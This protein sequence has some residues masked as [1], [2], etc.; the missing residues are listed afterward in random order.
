MK[1]KDL[2]KEDT[3]HCTTKEEALKVLEIAHYS[4]LT[5]KNKESFL[6]H[7]EWDKY[8]ENTCYSIKEGQMGN[9]NDFKE[10]APNNKII[11]AEDFILD[12]ILDLPEL[13]EK[14]VEPE[15][16]EFK[17]KQWL[18]FEGQMYPFIIK[19]K[20]GGNDEPFNFYEQYG[21]N[22]ELPHISFLDEKFDDDCSLSMY[23]APATPEQIQKILGKAAKLKGCKIGAELTIP[24][25]ASN[26][27]GEFVTID[28]K[29]KSYD[30]EKDE[31]SF[32]DII[33]YS[34]GEWAKLKKPVK[35]KNFHDEVRKLDPA[36]ALRLVMK[37]KGLQ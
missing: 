6:K 19:Y 3:I 8:K 25:T 34:K 23:E 21:I 16:T 24:S 17:D 4:G 30:A 37:L 11:P 2:K 1:L 27:A 10:H 28:S 14:Y 20:S 31:L 36:T 29:D 9:I 7:N 18:Y 33:V 13:K 32:G 5:W 22:K 15:R 35:Q 12:N 26:K